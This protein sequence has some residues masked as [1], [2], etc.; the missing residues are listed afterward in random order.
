MAV[1]ANPLDAIRQQ[2]DDELAGRDANVGIAF[3]AELFEQFRS[4][5][6][7][8]LETMGV[9]GSFFLG[10]RLPAYRRTHFVFQTWDIAPGEYRIGGNN[11]PK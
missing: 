3:G 8:T 1:E 6:W 4:N 10:A 5:G 9:V 7:F 11:L 2:L